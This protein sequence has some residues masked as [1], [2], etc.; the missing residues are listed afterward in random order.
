[1]IAPDWAGAIEHAMPRGI[2]QVVEELRMLLDRAGYRG[3]PRIL[4]AHSYGALVAVAYAS[5]YPAEIAGMV[6]VD[7]VSASEWS[8]PSEARRRTL[9]GGI[10]SV[11]ARGVYS[12]GW[13][14]FA[15]P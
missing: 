9:R 11:A 6:L 15:S 2:W 3:I 10:H 12:H 14:W 4:V 7:P 13:G 1:M 5:R 8:E